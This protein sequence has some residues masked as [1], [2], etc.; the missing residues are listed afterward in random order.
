MTKDEQEFLE[1]MI[2]FPDAFNLTEKGLNTV[3]GLYEK[4]KA[5]DLVFKE[6]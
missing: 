5:C 6:K 1:E 4:L 2:D 3:K